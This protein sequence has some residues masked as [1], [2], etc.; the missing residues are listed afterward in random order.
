MSKHWVDV[1]PVDPV[2]AAW[3]LGA[4]ESEALSWCYQH[5]GHE[6]IIDDGAARKCALAMGV[7]V[8]GTLGILL[9]AKK[10]GHI[11]KIAPLFDELIR[12]G[13]RIDTKVLDTALDWAGEKPD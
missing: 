9:L 13:L 4:G 2:I 12:F 1:R 6:V 11:S 3:D 7:P 8:R 10:E 5:P